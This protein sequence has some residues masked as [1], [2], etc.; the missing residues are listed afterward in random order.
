VADP[1]TE[2][3]LEI[4]EQAY[5][6]L[7]EKYRALEAQVASL[8]HAA[9]AKKSQKPPPM[10]VAG[11]GQSLSLAVRK[12]VKKEL[13]IVCVVCGRAVQARASRATDQGPACADCYPTR[14]GLE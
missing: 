5:A 2:M 8:V 13:E 7:E 3:R 11:A 9:S 6:A 12:K 4:L 1:E 10:R 14:A